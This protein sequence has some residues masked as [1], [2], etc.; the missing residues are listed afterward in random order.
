M[1]EGER[2]WRGPLALAALTGA[3]VVL[4]LAG[5]PGPLR[6][7]ASRWLSS[8]AVA[9]GLMAIAAFALNVVLGARLPWV[10][11][12]V[13]GLEPLYAL[14]RA[15]GRVVYG[16]V[17]LHVCLV[18]ASRSVVSLE[19]VPR[20][21]WPSPSG[22]LLIGVVAFVV[23]T[24]G[25]YLT[26]YARLTH[27][28]F[29]YVQRVL[30]GTFALAALHV[31]LTNRAVSSSPLLR[32]YLFVLGTGAVLAWIY[33]S[34]LGNLLVRRFD[35]V[36]TEVR[37]L[38]PEVVEITMGPVD[39]ALHAKPG[40]FVFVTF[41]SDRFNAQFHPISMRATGSSAVIELRPGDSRDQFHPF[42]LTSTPNDRELRL[43]VKA[44]GSF[45]RAL[46]LLEPGAAA[47]VEGPYGGF[48]YLNVANPRQVWL[49]GGIGITP[50]LSMARSLEPGGR[51]ILLMHGV[52]TR[53]EAFF[54]EELREIETRVPD[55]RVLIVPEDETGF[56]NAG[57]IEKE[58]GLEGTDFFI[59][60][61]P[62]MEEALFRQLVAKGVPEERI[63]SERF[64]FGPKG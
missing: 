37:R 62:A 24:I 1:T 58:F 26:L 34:V 36:V 2:R 22:A 3:P 63:H 4:W 18:L 23:M 5:D 52:K 28:S 56:I 43:V 50:F 20:L 54:A 10:H 30:G 33:R 17:M 13:G 60:G 8:L 27:E 14:H 31:F 46:H 38:D 11:R 7:D 57:M 19:Q 47:R 6:G 21:F 49:A 32:G 53:A 9:A 64:A 16:F 40:Q 44:V 55:L 51:Q 48:S 61:P 15:N 35:H 25:I 12:A 42:S 45:T 41:Y 39:R 59:V 29:V